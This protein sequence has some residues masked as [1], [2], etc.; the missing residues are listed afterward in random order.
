MQDCSQFDNDRVTLL[1]PEPK[2]PLN[3][4]QNGSYS[5]LDFSMKNKN[6]SLKKG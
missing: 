3:T 5:I 1:L 2:S 4:M 6:M